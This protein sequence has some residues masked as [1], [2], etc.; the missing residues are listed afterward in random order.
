MKEI[1]LALYSLMTIG[2]LLTVI[3]L[4][5]IKNGPLRKY[6]ITLFGSLLFVMLYRIV[7]V[8]FDHRIE[9][10]LEFMKVLVLV[11]AT[12]SFIALAYYLYRHYKL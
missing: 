2:C 5:I 6:L 9:Q 1:I 10:E 11:P 4:Y 3:R 8:W 12:A 7:N